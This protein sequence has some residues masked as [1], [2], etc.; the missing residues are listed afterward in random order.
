MN[1]HRCNL[2]GADRSPYGFRLPGHF[3]KLEKKAYLWACAD[4]APMA[5]ARWKAAIAKSQV[6][7]DAPLQPERQ[8]SLG[9]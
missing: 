5:E 7:I 6:K 3:S 8:G 9:L 4:C 1:D 2:C